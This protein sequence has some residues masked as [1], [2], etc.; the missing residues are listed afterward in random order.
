MCSMPT[1][2]SNPRRS[3]RALL[4]EGQ[5]LFGGGAGLRQHCRSA[6]RDPAGWSGPARP[7][8]PSPMP[9]LPCGGNSGG[10]GFSKEAVMQQ[11]SQN[12]PAQLRPFCS[13]PWPRPRSGP[14]KKQKSSSSTGYRMGELRALKVKDLDVAGRTLPLAAEFT[15]GRRAARQPVSAAPVR[16]LAASVSEAVL[17]APGNTTGAQ[18]KAAGAESLVLAGDRWCP[19]RGSNPHEVA[20][21]GF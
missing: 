6:R 3:G 2:T 12:S 7:Q 14:K 8:P 16:K 5:P 17:G 19:G 18:R 4:A 1:E 11:P 15:K 20:L 13:P 9:S 21:T 10:I